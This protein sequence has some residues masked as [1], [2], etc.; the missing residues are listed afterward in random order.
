MDREQFQQ[1]VKL[2]QKLLPVSPLAFGTVAACN[3]ENRMVKAVIEP[4]GVETGWCKC[5]QGAY[6]DKIG[7]EVLIGRVTG[8]D[9]QQYVIIGIVE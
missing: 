8:N 4:S 9:T 7:I 5:L 1:T 3:S 2:I 6:T